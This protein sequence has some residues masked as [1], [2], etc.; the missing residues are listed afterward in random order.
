MHVKTLSL[1]KSL[2]LSIAVGL[3]VV[4][5]LAVGA[6]Q[7]ANITWTGT[8]SNAWNLGTNW[9]GGVAPNAYTDTATISTTANNPV[10]IST[11]VFLG[12]S[13]T[14]LTIGST[15]S[16]TALDI[17]STGT[18]GMQGGISL[19]TTRT[20]TVEGVLRND[21]AAGTAYAIGGASITGLTLV[22]GT[23]SSLNGGTWTFS[24]P[25]I[26]YGIIS[27]SFTNSSTINANVSGQTLHI[28]G[29][30][31]TGG[32]LTSGTNGAI[33]SLESF[34]T[35]GT[36]NHTGEV[37]FNGATLSGVTLANSG[38]NAFQVTGNST[39]TG[40]IARNTNSPINVNGHTLSVSGLTLNNV[41]GGTACIAVGTGTLNN[42]SAAATSITNGDAVTLA[43]GQITN[44]GGGIFTIS[45]QISG[46]GT[47]FGPITSAN[48][49]KAS[50][51][52]LFL[53][54][55]GGAIDVHNTTVFTN[56]SIG[57]VADLKGAINFG[58]GGFL[59]S[60]PSGTNGNGE[61]RLDGA[62]L[63]T[64]GAINSNLLGQGAVNVVNTSSLVGTYDCSA[65]F[66]INS[67]SQF[68]IAGS[69]LNVN[70]GSLTATGTLAVGNGVL[71][72]LT[73][74]AYALGGSGHIT[75]AGGTISATNGAG[76]TSTTTLDGYG[77]VTAAYTN[78]GKVIANGHGTEQTLNFSSLATATATNADGLGWFATQHGKLALP[79]IAVAADGA[80]NWGSDPATFKLVNS[81]GMNFTGVGVSGSVAIALLATDNATVPAGLVN[82][83]SVW[84]VNPGALTFGSVAMTFRY[85]DAAAAALAIPESSLGLFGYNGAWVQIG[86]TTD[87]TNKLLTTTSG[88]PAFYQ[89][90]AIAPVPEPMTLGLLV[91]GGMGMLARRRNRATRSAV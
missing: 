89:D 55:T 6:S 20:M 82:P 63:T 88:L 81:I 15:A 16:A 65:T 56:G 29:N 87:L 38:T 45:A 10:S 75:V 90:F 42:S 30:A 32:T 57:D 14:S 78:N 91:L 50:G 23:I 40:T 52:I 36:I 67:G 71:N 86:T 62:T 53:D 12:S 69:T 1:R 33:L 3:V 61:I 24:R 60:S 47:V 58:A 18:L 51:G 70:V 80:Q 59:Y 19:G 26:G 66:G 79:A 83:I 31:L 84:S 68:N 76:F 48:S 39:L 41:S 73:A 44:T 7:A 8:T 35:G 85:D 74:S 54:G 25:I 49:T 17:T 46:F 34:I 9:A 4:G 77:N 64:T 37:D 21:G 27:A 72:N 13:T 43:G 11:I 28:T 22:G 5:A 2:G